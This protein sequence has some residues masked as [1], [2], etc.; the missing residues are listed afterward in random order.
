MNYTAYI[1]KRFNFLKKHGFKTTVYSERTDD[2]IC[3]TNKQNDAIEICHYLASK[4]DGANFSIDDLI[5]NSYYAVDVIMTKNGLR[6]NIFE[7]KDL[8]GEKSLSVLKHNIE[9]SVGDD[10]QI[11]L[12]ADFVERN[13]EKI[14][15]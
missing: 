13:I 15:C 14:I 8:F 3:Y 11:E 10:K 2:E 9:E 12:Y 4:Y 5:K 1:K 7:W 6:A